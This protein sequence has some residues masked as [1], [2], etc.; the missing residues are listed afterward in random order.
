MFG[1]SGGCHAAHEVVLVFI[2]HHV[3]HF[4]DGDPGEHEGAVHK[5]SCGLIDGP[6]IH[7]IQG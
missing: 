1:E 6:Q 5:E 7:L 4:S 2:G 3:Q